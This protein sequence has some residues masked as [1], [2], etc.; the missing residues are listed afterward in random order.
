M[1]AR[2]YSLRAAPCYPK[3]ALTHN[4]PHA[5]LFLF[6]L[7]PVYPLS[8]ASRAPTAAASP[9][10]RE[11]LA[12]AAARVHPRLQGAVMTWASSTFIAVYIVMMGVSLYENGGVEELSVNPMIVS[13]PNSSCLVIQIILA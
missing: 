7:R 1:R 13:H 12:A 6:L 3:L 9:G 5:A 11:R 8:A 10:R 2:V 4:I